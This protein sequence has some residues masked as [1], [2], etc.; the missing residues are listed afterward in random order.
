MAKGKKDVEKASKGAKA[1]KKDKS[2]KKSGAAKKSRIP[3]PVQGRGHRLHM[4]FVNALVWEIGTAPIWIAGIAAHGDARLAIWAVAVLVTY[5]GVIASHPLPGRI[6]PF[7]SDSQIYAEHLLERFRL[8]FLIALGETVLTMG[9][10]FTGEPFA[11]DR[12]LTLTITFAGAVAIWWCYFQSVEDTIADAAEQ[13]EDAGTVGW[14]A[15]L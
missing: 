4:H 14:S 9:T 5:G 8:F 1:G 3:Q 7:K 10:A 13:A 12:L 11:V 15:A 2:A 6:S